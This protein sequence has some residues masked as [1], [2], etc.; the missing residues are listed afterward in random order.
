MNKGRLYLESKA[1][2]FLFKHPKINGSIAILKLIQGY[3]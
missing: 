2:E 3:F 1:S